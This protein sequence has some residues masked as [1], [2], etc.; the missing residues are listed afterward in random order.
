MYIGIYFV[1]KANR[2]AT[3]EHRSLA[4]GICATDGLLDPRQV[5]GG[6]REVDSVPAHWAAGAHAGREAEGIEGYLELWTRSDKQ[7]A[8]WFILAEP[9]E[10]KLEYLVLIVTNAMQILVVHICFDILSNKL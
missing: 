10:A 1:I 3:D 2:L 8:D 5:P 6:H 9:G 7:G 4:V